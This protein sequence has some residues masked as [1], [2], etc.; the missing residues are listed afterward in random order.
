MGIIVLHW[1]YPFLAKG[2]KTEYGQSRNRE[3]L[4]WLANTTRPEHRPSARGGFRL[5]RR[6]F[7]CTSG[8]P[9]RLAETVSG[10]FLPLY[11]KDGKLLNAAQRALGQ[12][13]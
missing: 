10:E 4:Q 8:S 12:Q 5:Q 1:T 6:Q 9:R 2:A 3:A 7:D 11:I 13:R